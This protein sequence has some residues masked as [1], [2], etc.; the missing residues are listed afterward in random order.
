MENEPWLEPQNFIRKKTTF[1]LAGKSRVRV[2][3]E[4]YIRDPKL[5]QRLST[6]D[7]VC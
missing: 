4:T 6:L 3:G 7:K 2:N 5:L 1:V